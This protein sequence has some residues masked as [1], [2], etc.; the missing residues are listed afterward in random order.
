MCHTLSCTCRPMCLNVSCTCVQT[1]NFPRVH[2]SAS[3]RAIE[4]AQFASHRDG[5]PLAPMNK[6]ASSSSPSVDEPAA[7]RAKLNRELCGVAPSCPKSSLARI[8]VSLNERGLLSEGLVTSATEDAVRK[9]IERATREMSNTST[10]Y[11][12]VLQDMELPCGDES[13]TWTYIPPLA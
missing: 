7:K 11:G 13:F 9:D 5:A 1:H 12:P 3:P 6:Q 10:P 2:E 4:P 8:L